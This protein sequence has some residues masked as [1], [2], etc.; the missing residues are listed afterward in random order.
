MQAG[1]RTP[2]SRSVR[3]APPSATWPRQ[4]T[5]SRAPAALGSAIEGIGEL[6]DSGRVS[7]LAAEVE[8]EL[9]QARSRADRGEVLE[10]PNE[11]E[12]GVLRL[13]ASD[14]S[15]REIGAKLFVSANT[16]RSH[17]RAIYHKLGVNSRAEAVARATALG[18]L[19]QAESP[20]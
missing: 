15:A 5:S 11:A 13:M 8:R 4:S 12:L 2:P 16:V 9:E 1:L 14:L 3:S 20:I 10:R 19:G 6:A 7:A 18:L 17:A